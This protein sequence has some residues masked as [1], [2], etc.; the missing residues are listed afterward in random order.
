MEF[1]TEVSIDE[2]KQSNNRVSTS[3]KKKIFIVF[4]IIGPILLVLGFLYLFGGIHPE[5]WRKNQLLKYLPS[6][7]KYL[8]I[9][10]TFVWR[11]ID[12]VVSIG[13][14]GKFGVQ[15]IVIAFILI[16]ISIPDKNERNYLMSLYTVSKIISVVILIWHWLMQLIEDNRIFDGMIYYIIIFI[17]SFAIGKIAGTIFKKVVRI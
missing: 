11:K 5:E 6:I 9:P 15:L 1:L 4:R 12:S 13:I 17:S 16:Y 10:I 3:N 8:I 2:S 14:N 7:S